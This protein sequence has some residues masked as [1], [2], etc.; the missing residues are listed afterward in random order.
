[1]FGLKVS[2]SLLLGV[3][4]AGGGHF[5][6][7][8]A[9][10]PG[11]PPKGVELK[12]VERGEARLLTSSTSGEGRLPQTAAT[13]LPYHCV[14]SVDRPHN[15]NTTRATINVHF[16]TRCRRVAPNLST[17]G[18]L[19]RSR[20]Y[21]W[22]HLTTRRGTKSNSRHLRVVAP[23]SCRPGDRH[24]YRG[25]ARFYVSGPEGRGSA[26]VYN[27]NDSEITCRG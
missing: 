12:D 27:Q 13:R 22:E 8:A 19:Y 10:V 15:S 3:V 25:Q 7:Q 9:A 26:H 20:W 4:L 18:A 21:G 5:P 6:A 11:D 16:D 24:R 17:E 23:K 14:A 1:M 2:S